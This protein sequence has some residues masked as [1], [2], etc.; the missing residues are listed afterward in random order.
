MLIHRLHSL[1][2]CY[3]CLYIPDITRE[4]NDRHVREARVVFRATA[5]EHPARICPTTREVRNARPSLKTSFEVIPPLLIRK[6]VV[7]GRFLTTSIKKADTCSPKARCDSWSSNCNSVRLVYITGIIFFEWQS[8]A[9]ETVSFS[10]RGH[11][12]D[13]FATS[14]S[15]AC[16]PSCCNRGERG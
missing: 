16:M 15:M 1:I 3:Q 10:N 12:V 13:I 5:T 9:S 6:P 14:I 8:S 7:S 11:F 4:N 2:H